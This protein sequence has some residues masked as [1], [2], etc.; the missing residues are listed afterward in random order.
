MDR[1]SVRGEENKLP[2]LIDDLKA[3]N[4][5]VI[6]KI[7][8]ILFAGGEHMECLDIT[9]EHARS[10]VDLFEVNLIP[11]I[12][13]DDTIDSMEWLANICHVYTEFKKIAVE[14]NDAD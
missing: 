4:L 13:E 3:E 2:R 9:K 12:R 5:T 10:M 11:L 6:L 7:Y 1:Q 14:K 8:N